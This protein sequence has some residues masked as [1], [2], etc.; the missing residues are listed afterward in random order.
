MKKAL[1]KKK[2][3]TKS[4]PKKSTFLD[5]LPK[6][7][8]ERLELMIRMTEKHIDPRGFDTTMSNQAARLRAELEDLKKENK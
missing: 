1:K 6:N 5:R 7:K 3:S 8:I 4:A 2:S